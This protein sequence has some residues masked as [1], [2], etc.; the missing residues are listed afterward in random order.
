MLE[1]WGVVEA[2]N[3][4]DYIRLYLVWFVKYQVA[5]VKKYDWEISTVSAW[6]QNTGCWSWR[7]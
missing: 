1:D 7:W 4:L 2:P 3:R 5:S 6:F